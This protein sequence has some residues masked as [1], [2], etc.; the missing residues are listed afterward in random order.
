MKDWI[1]KL[2][3]VFVLGGLAGYGAGLF[4]P[5]EGEET[6]Q[7][8]EPLYWV[9]P[10]DPDYKRDEPGQSPMGMDL[11]PVYEED[12]EERPPGTIDVSGL[13]QQQLALTKARVERKAVPEQLRASGLAVFN[14]AFLERRHSRV[15]GWIT[16]LSVDDVGDTV[17]QGD[18]LYRIYSPALVSVQQEMITALDSG[19]AGLIAAA[20]DRLRALG[21]SERTIANLRK[22]KRVLRELPFYSGQDGVV[23]EL[24][25]RRGSHVQP[26]D[27]LVAVGDPHKLWIEADLLER[28]AALVDEGDQA[29]VRFDALPG[30]SWTGR[31]S[32]IYPRIDDQTRSARVR[33][34]LDNPDG[35]VMP[36]MFARVDIRGV[37]GKPVLSIPRSALIRAQEGDRVV[38]QVDETA[39]RTVP[40]R[41]GRENGDRV[42]ILE[43][44]SEGDEVVTSAQFLID[45]ESA[46]AGARLR[47]EGE[48]DQ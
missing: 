25:I 18:L 2:V 40:V 17:E 30:E 16:E 37:N 32:Y 31:V 11:V 24:G 4:L 42:V 26:N 48:N 8:K 22:Q 21:V 38:Q 39:F 34:L 19:E 9:A 15:E 10:M 47:L 44:L 35:R 13:V 36:G 28:Q 23:S 33:V 43:G 27:L 14:G 6:E 12:E 1:I 45:S 20:E 5:G 3:P 41:T 7:E 46:R 29:E